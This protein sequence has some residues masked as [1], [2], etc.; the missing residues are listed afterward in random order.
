METSRSEA[1]A[2]IEKAG[3]AEGYDPE[4]DLEADRGEERPL[5]EAVSVDLPDD[6]TDPEAA[7]IAVAIGA[8][9][10]DREAAAAA[11]AGEEETWEGRRWTFA[12]RIEAMQGR[13]VRV[14]VETP[15]D[16]WTAAG[17][18]DRMR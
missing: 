11:A 2:E 17:R 8:H 9:L 10:R 14:P 3:G 16:A 7:A 1:D 15:T 12:G 13:N 18:T 4:R 6:A 5:P